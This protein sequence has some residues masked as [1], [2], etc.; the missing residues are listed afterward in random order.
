MKLL[1]PI[2]VIRSGM[3]RKGQS[4]QGR[5][6]DKQTRVR[7]EEKESIS[8]NLNLRILDCQVFLT[9]L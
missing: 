5:Q 4:N 8:F 2:I 6:A 7:N 9:R 1:G 3:K